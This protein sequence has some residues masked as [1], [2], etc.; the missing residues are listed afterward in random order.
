MVMQF[1]ADVK[2]KIEMTFINNLLN[3]HSKKIYKWFLNM[4]LS[5]FTLQREKEYK[6]TTFKMKV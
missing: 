4:I 3:V 1:E 6:L 5:C 2:T